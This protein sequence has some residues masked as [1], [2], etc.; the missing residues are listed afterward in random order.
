MIMGNFVVQKTIELN[1]PVAQVW[2]ALT[3][4]EKTRKYFF[5]CR[6]FSDW[7]PGSAIT[8]KGRIFLIKKIE[9]RGEIIEATPNVIL[10]YQLNN[11]SGGTK[12]TSVVTDILTP[13][14]GKTI[15]SVSDDVGDGPGAK[16]RYERS[17]KGWDK[18]LAGL[19]KLVEEEGA[20]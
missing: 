18:V 2:D 15:L 13:E 14:N 12:T 16:E 1:A 3:N 10:K 7:K 17:L 5:H 11:E 6:V 8:F 9:L 19:K 4:P 20:H